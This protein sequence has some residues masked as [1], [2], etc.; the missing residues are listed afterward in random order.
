MGICDQE[1]GFDLRQQLIGPNISSQMGVG[2]Y[3]TSRKVFELGSL[4]ADLREILELEKCHVS[5]R[6]DRAAI[7]TPWDSFGLCPTSLL[8]DSSAALVFAIKNHI[9][10]QWMGPEKSH[11]G[12]V[13]FATCH[14]SSLKVSCV[15]EEPK[16][17]CHVCWPIYV[18]N[19]GWKRTVL[20]VTVEVESTSQSRLHRNLMRMVR[21]ECCF[22]SLMT[23][24]SNRL[25]SCSFLSW[26]Q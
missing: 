7:I 23:S 1:Y 3:H 5:L 21:R 25:R 17:R 11:V 16:P 18:H 10:W 20:V 9:F 2:A 24:S 8:S 12:Q 14:R 19:S 22:R 13:L 26:D 15:V 6:N 4:R